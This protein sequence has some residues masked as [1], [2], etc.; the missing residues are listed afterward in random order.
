MGRRAFGCW[1]KAIL[2]HQ[3]ERVSINLYTVQSAGEME[4]TIGEGLYAHT[5]D[6]CGVGKVGG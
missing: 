1:R 5:V 4:K 6:G 3:D 2:V